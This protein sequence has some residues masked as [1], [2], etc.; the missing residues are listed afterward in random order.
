MPT[1]RNVESIKKTM[2]MQEDIFKHQ[3]RELHRLYS[4]QRMLMDELKMEI[5]NHSSKPWTPMTIASDINH[6]LIIN[7]HNSTSQHRSS[8]QYCSRDEHNTRERR[9]SCSGATM[10]MARGFDLERPAEGN[11]STGISVDDDKRAAGSSFY[12]PQKPI[13]RCEDSEVELTLSIGASSGKSPK[14]KDYRRLH[15]HREVGF[16]ETMNMKENDS[17]T[18][19]FRSERGEDC[20]G[21]TTSM[22]RSSATSDQ[23][24]KRPHWLFQGLSINRT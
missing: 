1:N 20:S 8:V 7:P 17:P 5:S 21:P 2:Q 13:N 18:S 10:K 16:I 6:S 14:S 24:R 23:E 11:L 9:G 3:V 4:V 19:I 15:T 22:S 12:I